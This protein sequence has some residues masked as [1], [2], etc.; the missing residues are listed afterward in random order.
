MSPSHCRNSR[1]T[2]RLV[3]AF[4]LVE[5]LV[6][7]AIVAVL[8]SLLLPTLARAKGAAGKSRCLSNLRQQ[9]LAWALYLGDGS[10]RFP[11]R[12]DLKT[13]QP[14]GYRPWSGW[15]SSSDPRSGWAWV[16]L[17]GHLDEARA[18]RCPAVESG[19][20]ARVDA[21]VQTALREG[22][23]GGEARTHHWMWRFDR[24]EDPVPDDNFWGRTVEGAVE[25]LRR[26]DNPVAGRPD[27]ASSVELAVDPYF[28]S[29]IPS[30]PS[31]LRGMS[32]HV[33]GR[34]RLMLDGHVEHLRDPRTR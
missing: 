17:R 15:P 25:A 8:A 22:V 29:T 16:V 14:G 9:G 6:V 7:V 5:L 28:P 19:P 1:A 13:N 26:A 10:F 2:R 20:L 3:R 23:D 27:G 24:F 33:G 18:F 31:E 32:S 4:T 21:V 11:D 30:V 34:N 12:R